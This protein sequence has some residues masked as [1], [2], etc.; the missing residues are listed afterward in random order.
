[1]RIDS[2]IIDG[3]TIDLKNIVIVIGSNGAGKTTFL[4]SL[5]ARLVSIDAQ[6][7]W[8]D[9]THTASISIN[10][11]EVT[12]WI[13]GHSFIRNSTVNSP[14]FGNSAYPLQLINEE[15]MFDQNKLEQIKSN[16]S[17]FGT[18]TEPNW[19]QKFIGSTVGFLRVENRVTKPHEWDTISVGHGTNQNEYMLDPLK[20]KKINKRLKNL[21]GKELV[22]LMR[23]N[24]GSWGLYIKDPNSFVVPT[25]R[26]NPSTQR[27]VM[28]Q[29]QELI[30]ERKV[31]PLMEV[32]H[33]TRAVLSL[34]SLLEESNCNVNFIDEP[35]L[36]LYPAA[37]KYIGNR[38]A[39]EADYRQFFIATHDNLFMESILNS[40]KEFTLLRLDTGYK[41]TAINFDRSALARISSEKKNLDVLSSGFHDGTIFVEGINDK[42]VYSNAINIKNFIPAN[43]TIAVIPC[44][45]MSKVKDH[46]KFAV[47][48][49][50]KL[51]VI[52]DFDSLIEKN[53]SCIVAI[54]ILRAMNKSNE[55][56]ESKIESLSFLKGKQGWKQ[57]LDCALLS[58]A[59]EG[60]I[61]DVLGSLSERG[62]FI[63]PIGELYNWFNRSKVECSPE[64]LL[65]IY[66]NNSNKKL[67]KLTDFLSNVVRYLNLKNT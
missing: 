58:A 23:S 45:N 36:H 31:T 48:V 16:I 52:V 22:S 42:Y 25:G 30:N 21:F 56:L 67:K 51:A 29:H 14:L 59:Q 6:W 44:G 17:G 4:E 53:G 50:A 1:M 60:L 3:R 34:L 28:R 15:Y 19:R 55:Q 33:G 49:Q 11:S 63:V 43:T 10:D 64:K 13:N 8:G 7:P 18:M 20:L 47:E 39:A 27:Q 38:I 9:I 65:A 62:L 24:P 5:F 54:E 32:S 61:K 2:I 66:R 41:I 40:G 46:I 35:E 37:R 12:N 26:L 57:G